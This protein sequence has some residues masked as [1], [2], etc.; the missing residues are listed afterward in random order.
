MPG[1]S[2]RSGLSYEQDASQALAVLEEIAGE[3]AETEAAR[4]IMV[5]DAPQV[6]ALLDLGDSAVTARIVVQVRP[7]EQ[8]AAERDLRRLIKTRFDER[9]VEIPFPRRT[10]YVKSDGVADADGAGAGAAGA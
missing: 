2:C 5:E 6:Q 9:G 3:W 8:F 1:R 10:V 7:G 4:E